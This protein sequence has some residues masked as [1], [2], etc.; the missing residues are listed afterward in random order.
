MDN[1]FRITGERSIWYKH[2]MKALLFV[3]A[4]SVTLL[5]PSAHPQTRNPALPIVTAAQIPVYPALTRTARIEGIVH[6]RI[7]T[8]GHAVIAAAIEDGHP[9]LA[10][11]AEE[12]V[13][14]WQFA[15]HVPL[16]YMVTYRFRISTKFGKDPRNATV[17]F[18]FPTDVEVINHPPPVNVR[19]GGAPPLSSRR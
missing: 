4:F 13:R 6:V 16:T 8:D 18:R 9:I 11:A 7:T 15:D 17:I 12:N 10:R 1:A 3:V 14:T 19:F 2:I 5:V